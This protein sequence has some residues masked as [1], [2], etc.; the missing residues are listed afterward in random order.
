MPS[1]SRLS[2]FR[3]KWLRPCFRTRRNHSTGN[4]PNGN[5]RTVPKFFARNDFGQD[6]PWPNSAL[7]STGR[8]VKIGRDMCTDVLY[9]VRT[10]SGAGNVGFRGPHGLTRFK[11]A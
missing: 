2:D 11:A 5:I 7:D 4:P 10:P 6:C 3:G 1:G 8:R 9:H